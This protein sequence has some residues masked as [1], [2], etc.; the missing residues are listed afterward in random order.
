LLFIAEFMSSKT[1]LTGFFIM[2]RK[3]AG[4][5][6]KQIWMKKSS[7]RSHQSNRKNYNP[8]CPLTKE[9]AT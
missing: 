6:E 9:R 5:I 1:Y 2:K 7:T 3:H 4:E 8:S